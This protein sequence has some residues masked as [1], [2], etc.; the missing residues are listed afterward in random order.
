MKLTQGIKRIGQYIALFFYLVFLAFPLFWMFFTSLKPTKEMQSLS[1]TILPQNPTFKHFITA[2]TEQELFQSM[3]N[4]TKVGILSTIGVLIIAVPAA[5]ALARYKTKMN[6]G[7]IGWVLVSQLFPAILIMVPLFLILRQLGLTNSHLGLALVYMVWTLPFVL[8]MLYGYIKGI[9]VELEQAAAI[10][11]ATRL[12]AIRKIVIPLLLPGIVATALFGFISA[13][14]EYFFALVLLRDPDLMT[15]PINL[16]R[17]T[18]YQGAARLGPLAAASF[19]ATIPSLI[20]FGFLQKGLISG[21]AQGA[22][23]D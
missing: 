13:W 14:N 21:L 3:L 10:D 17:F 4:S 23:K 7:V 8:M 11:G 15:L 16:A 22:V 12:Q 18:G 20:L 5:Y 1:A 19:V 6:K 9:P 2:F